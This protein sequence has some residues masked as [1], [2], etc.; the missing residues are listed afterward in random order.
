M[1][2]EIEEESSGSNERFKL[3]DQM[4]LLEFR[5]KFV[6]KSP[7]SPDQGFWISRQDGA[8]NLIEGNPLFFITIRVFH[9]MIDSRENAGPVLLRFAYF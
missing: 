2:I 5:D 1:D 3:H 4:D 9:L 6:I 7:E 8:I